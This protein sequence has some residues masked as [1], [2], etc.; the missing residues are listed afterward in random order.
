MAGIKAVR[1]MAEGVFVIHHHHLCHL[2]LVAATV[3]PVV[4]KV[5][6]L[7]E[8]GGR[9]GDV[10]DMGNNVS[11]PLPSCAATAHCLGQLPSTTYSER[12]GSSSRVSAVELGTLAVK[13]VS[14]LSPSH[15]KASG[16]SEQPPSS[17][18]SEKVVLA[19]LL[20]K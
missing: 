16:C 1:D 15:A 14:S 9:V 8:G 19:R 5:G 10:E 13:V 18:H 7:V 12:S 20:E 4:Q 6:E 17:R 2:L 3:C 11:S